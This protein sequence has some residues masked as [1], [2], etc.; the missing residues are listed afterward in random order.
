MWTTNRYRI[1]HTQI[2]HILLIYLHC[3][4]IRHLPMQTW[5]VYFSLSVQPLFSNFDPT[6]MTPLFRVF[7]T[8]SVLQDRSSYHL[9]RKGFFSAFTNVLSAHLIRDPA[10]IYLAFYTRTKR[11]PESR[12]FLSLRPWWIYKKRLWFENT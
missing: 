5:F 4:I 11:L 12:E 10:F 8:W 7:F 9:K 2:N 6:L 1:D 3:D